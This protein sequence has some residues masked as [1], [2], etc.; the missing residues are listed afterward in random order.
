MKPEARW[1]MMY[2]LLLVEV[3][4]DWKASFAPE[5]GTAHNDGLTGRDGDVQVTWIRLTNLTRKACKHT[6]HYSVPKQTMRL[7]GKADVMSFWT[8]MLHFTVTAVQKLYR[9]LLDQMRNTLNGMFPGYSNYNINTLPLSITK[10]LSQC[11]LRDILGAGRHG[12]C[13]LC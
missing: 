12:P 10:Q 6:S 2:L 8:R 1:R 5:L 7:G 3:S 4:Q 9:P 11:A 13:S